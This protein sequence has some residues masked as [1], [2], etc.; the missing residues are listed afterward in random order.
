[1]EFAA[2]VVRVVRC[3][4]RPLQFLP[5]KN[6]QKKIRVCFSGL[7]GTARGRTRREQH[8]EPRTQKNGR[9]NFFRTC[10]H[11]VR[12]K[13]EPWYFSPK[14]SLSMYLFTSTCV[15]VCIFFCISS[16]ISVSFSCIYLCMYLY[17]FIF[18][19]LC[20][21]L[22]VCSFLC[23]FYISHRAHLCLRFLARQPFDSLYLARDRSP[24]RNRSLAR[25]TTKS[26]QLSIVPTLNLH[27]FLA[28][29]YS[30]FV[31]SEGVESE[32]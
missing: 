31:R 17:F 22:N 32:K 18:V 8:Q 10:F 19:S 14:F 4:A 3:A 25:P 28:L 9:A 23:L 24:W 20:V 16:D 13:A 5:T 12:K 30:P 15:S 1:M 7:P 2:W 21:S 6:R 11:A 26:L 27:S 29:S